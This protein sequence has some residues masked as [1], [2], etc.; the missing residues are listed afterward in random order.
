[1][2]LDPGGRVA[3]S[4]RV[5]ARGGVGPR[6]LRVA[7]SQSAVVALV[8]GTALGITA[9]RG[10]TLAFEPRHLVEAPHRTL[11]Y[12]S[13]LPLLAAWHEQP[14]VELFRFRATAGEAPDRL[15]LVTLHTYTGV[16]WSATATYWP[17][18]V[19]GDTLLPAGQR[20]SAATA[21][22]SVATLDGVWLPG[23][24]RPAEVSLSAVEYEA[25]GG[26]LALVDATLKPGLSYRVSAELD[27]P[28]ID[29]VADAGVPPVTEAG[30]LL[31]LPRI[32]ADF[33][34][35]ARTVAAGARTPF[36]RAVLLE[37]A[38]R[39]GR[40]F[41]ALAPV[42]SS[43]ARLDA[44]LFQPAGSG[45]GAQT[46]SSEQ[47]AAAF[48]VLARSVGLPSRVVLGFDRGQGGV[49]RGRD[50]LAW[51]EIYFSGYGWYAF[52]P[53]PGTADPA[54]DRLKLAV[55]ARIPGQG[56]PGSTATATAT[57]TVTAAPTTP[58]PT[59]ARSTPATAPVLTAPTPG[60]AQPLIPLAAAAT[61]LLLAIGGLALARAA[62]RARHRRAG[63]RGAWSEVLDLL[64]LM[65]RPA[66]RSQPAVRVADDLAM[67]APV[68]EA[69]SHPAASLRPAAPHPALLIAHAAQ[70]A[71]FAPGSP[72]PAQSDREAQEAWTALGPLRRAAR[73]ATPLHLRLLWTIDPRPLRRRRPP[74]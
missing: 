61:A 50:A 23:L 71:A 53:T 59:P 25:D 57:P 34:A 30:A 62:R 31:D 69:A 13:P 14:D 56:R 6:R 40:A 16:A 46:G 35:Y 27:T 22:F 4:T 18:G 74:S 12:P 5:A 48:A 20:R 37:F 47:F 49:V 33:T 44:F 66:P 63:A 60:G 7:V 58:R 8:A 32:P 21:D 26:S 38:V 65:G 28:L 67:A 17:V 39:E 55:L 10:P 52:D 42:G 51:P 72:D 19:V 68:R 9:V 29:D 43:Y 36:E 2:W 3:R 1:M 15:R 11:S 70:R 54:V 64:V 73:A 24:G 41:D 45:E